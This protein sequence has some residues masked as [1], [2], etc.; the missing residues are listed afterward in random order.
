MLQI[1]CQNLGQSRR[2]RQHTFP[3][4]LGFAKNQL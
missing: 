4:L 1:I 3:A 2:Q